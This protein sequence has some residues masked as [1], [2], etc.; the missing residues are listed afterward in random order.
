MR[1]SLLV[2]SV[3]SL[4]SCSVQPVTNC[5]QVPSRP[6]KPVLSVEQDNS[7]PDPIYQILSDREDLDEAYIRALLQRIEANNTRCR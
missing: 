3:A 5:I 6:A 1:L 4:L 7:I 2:L